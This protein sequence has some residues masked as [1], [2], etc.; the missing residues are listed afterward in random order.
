MYAY[1]IS[2]T[3]IIGVEINPIIVPEGWVTSEEHIDPFKFEYVDGQFISKVSAGTTSQTIATTT[4]LVVKTEEDIIAEITPY[5]DLLLRQSDWTQLPDA[6]I[7]AE[8]KESMKEWRQQLRDFPKN[9]RSL[10]YKL[11]VSPMAKGV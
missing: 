10:G 4:D 11:P 7:S 3:K 1:Q 2:G 5:R 8:L 9:A 6:P